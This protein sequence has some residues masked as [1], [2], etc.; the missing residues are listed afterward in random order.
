MRVSKPVWKLSLIC[1]AIVWYGLTPL[2]TWGAGTARRI[3]EYMGTPV[4]VQLAV[5][6]S[7]EVELPEDIV[8]I[9]TALSPQEATIE[10]R[11]NNLFIQ[12]LKTTAGE[13][14]AV[15]T[16]GASYILS[17][18]TP[19][20]GRD[21]S[22]RIVPAGRQAQERLQAT[23][24]LT[25]LELVKA[26][27]REEVP[28][29]VQHTK[30]SGHK[31]YEDDAVTLTMQEA[32]FAPVMRGYVLEAENRTGVSIPVP[33]QNLEMPGLLAVAAD[34]QLLY[35]R[36]QTVEEELAAAHRCKV[37]LVVK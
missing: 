30:G 17:L 19:Q 27:V 1:T 32:F 23:Q 16:S 12:P 7:G 24:K 6:K 31:V 14:F 2:P 8:D 37:Y 15:T 35:P 20:E 33:V 3:V 9:V 29:G 22:L 21:V 28:A 10:S 11:G 26:M 18:S 25:A 13:L 5:G 36:P 4:P 34:Q